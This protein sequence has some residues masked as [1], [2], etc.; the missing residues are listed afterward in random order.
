[1]HKLILAAIGATAFAVPASAQRDPVFDEGMDERIARAIPPAAEVEAM[2]PVMDSMVGALLDVEVG[3]L[4]DAADPYRR[5][6]GYGLPGRTLGALGRRNDPHF[7]ERL[8]GSIYGA[9][10]DMGRMMQAFA[11]AAPTLTRSL[12]EMERGM[13]A[14][15]DDY[16]RRRGAP[17]PPSEDWEAEEA[18]PDEPYPDEQD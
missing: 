4:L 16:H 3:P 6:P 8:R 5:R 12:Q 1:M 17:P 9:T 11:A 15:I 18:Y 10:A 13:A 7:E 2:A 14:A